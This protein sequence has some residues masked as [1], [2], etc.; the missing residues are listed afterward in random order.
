MNL[1]DLSPV[2]NYDGDFSLAGVDAN[3][4]DSTEEMSAEDEMSPIAGFEGIVGQSSALREVLQQVEMVAGTDST[5]LL[6]GETGTGKELIAR[7]IHDRS[8]RRNRALVKVNCAAIP[9]GLLESELFGHERGAFTGAITQKIGRLEVA[10]QGSLFLDEIGDIPLDL[11]PK[12]LR[13]LQ[14]REFERLG[15][16]RTKEVNVRV[17][18]ATHRNLEEMIL[19]RQFRSDLYYRLNV[20]PISIPPLRERPEDIPLLVQHFV[21]QFAKRMNKRIESISSETLEALTRYPWPGNIRELQNVIERAVVVYQRGNLSVKKSW[22]SR[23]SSPTGTAT[24]PL[25]RRSALEDRQIIGAALA[26]SRGR[27]SGPSGAA[28][29]LGVPP[30]TLESKIRSMNINKYSYRAAAE[31][32]HGSSQSSRI[33]GGIAGSETFDVEHVEELTNGACIA[34]T[35]L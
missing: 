23:A 31:N 27:V 18:A 32:R 35:K 8:G 29:K 2:E 28:A 5:V 19:E 16:T 34:V 20:F 4:N 26:E 22:L 12:L 25:L 9:S 24:Q 7:G 15:S 14:E 30:S 6:L 1:T 13:V 10:D 11:Q 21:Q 17:V 33:H 3:S